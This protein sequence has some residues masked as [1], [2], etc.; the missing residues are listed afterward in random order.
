MIGFEQ[1]DFPRVARSQ[2][3]VC[4]LRTSYFQKRAAQEPTVFT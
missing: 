1:C 2:N 4:T 3:H